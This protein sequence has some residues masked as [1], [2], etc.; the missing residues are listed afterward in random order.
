MKAPAFL[1]KFGL[2]SSKKKQAEKA[3][4]AASR[5][6]E[7]QIEQSLAV[8]TRQCLHIHSPAICRPFGGSVSLI[9][10]LLNGQQSKPASIASS[11]HA[12]SE[13]LSAAEEPHHRLRF[14][15]TAHTDRTALRR[16]A[17]H[18]E[19]TIVEIFDSF[20]LEDAALEDALTQWRCDLQVF[21]DRCQE[22]WNLHFYFVFLD[23][24]GDRD[25]LSAVIVQLQG[26]LET[27]AAGVA[28]NLCHT[29]PW[30]EAAFKTLSE[31]GAIQVLRQRHREALQHWLSAAKDSA[32][33]APEKESFWGT[34][35]CNVFKVSWPDFAEGFCKTFCK[36]S[37]CPQDILERLRL[38]VATGCR[39]H[40]AS[41]AWDNL[42]KSYDTVTALLESLTEEVL[43][44]LDGN[45]YVD[46]VNL[47]IGAPVLP[48][49]NVAIAEAGVSAPGVQCTQVPKPSNQQQVAAMANRYPDPPKHDGQQGSSSLVAPVSP[50]SGIYAGSQMQAFDIPTPQDVHMRTGPLQPGRTIGW[51]SYIEQ[52]CLQNRPWWAAPDEPPEALLAET[53][54]GQDGEEPLRVLAIRAVKGNMQATRRALVLRVRSGDLAHHK[55]V[56][57]MPGDSPPQD[58]DNQQQAD[59][60]ALVITPND[61]N[62]NFGC[63]TKFGRGSMRRVMVP[64]MVMTEPIAS[65]AHFNIVFDQQNQT[66]Q[67]MDA[68]SKWGTFLK[69]G[70]EGEALSCSDWLHV[71][72]VELVVR[73]CGGSCKSHMRHADRRHQSISLSRPTFSTRSCPWAGEKRFSA[74]PW[75]LEFGVHHDADDPHAD[76]EDAA[77]VEQAADLVAG[78]PFKSCESPGHKMRH[79]PPVFAADK[80]RINVPML[81]TETGRKPPVELPIGP[82][83]LDFISGPR[84]GERV[85]VTDRV[86]NF[87][88]CNTCTIQVSDPTLPNVSRKHC[89]F[90]HAGSGWVVKDNKSTNGTW[91]RLS[92][93]LE[94][95][96]PVDLRPG[97]SF[98]A[99][100]H[101]L[102]VEEAE[103]PRWWIPSTASAM[104]DSFIK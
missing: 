61:R 34:N 33:M 46:S 102:K 4:L 104:L 100:V 18:M 78:R 37:S 41:I 53:A 66:Y 3:V 16:F 75:Q 89:I 38:R 32:K 7:H 69:L 36:G 29:R 45:I 35:F 17:G 1:G 85:L 71:G 28:A 82:L 83:E 93:V 25:M 13:F 31:R 14:A 76:D 40:V 51:S 90:E 103:L 98:M 49:V 42:V 9:A 10:E 84:M 73:Y 68:G 59:L 12:A 48:S 95:S 88:R 2:G 99:G 81:K 50:N 5:E 15:L 77:V 64:D 70:S 65:R 67:L 56:L 58:K 62:L 57:V 54:I 92:C 79:Q 11:L 47:P 26:R 52:L 96:T 24:K 30:V 21:Q 80:T 22:A 91:K 97:I 94:P 72:N 55:P 86:C 74:L 101:E 19:S 43:Q 60:P 6:L 44:D 8:L 27:S 23:T 87:G 20:G 63:V 39:H